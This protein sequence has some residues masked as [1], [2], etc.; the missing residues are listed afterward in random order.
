MFPC[1]ALNA[2][3]DTINDLMAFQGDCSY[4]PQYKVLRILGHK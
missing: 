3:R 2:A 1:V 4:E